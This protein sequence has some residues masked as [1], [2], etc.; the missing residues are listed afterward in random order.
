[1]KKL[2]NNI[3]YQNRELLTG[4]HKCIKSSNAMNVTNATDLTNEFVCET[5]VL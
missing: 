5:S 1:M 3:C 4:V 2:Q